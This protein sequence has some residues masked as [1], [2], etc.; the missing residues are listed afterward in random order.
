[1][2]AS[3]KW[4][5]IPETADKVGVTIWRLRPEQAGDTGARLMVQRVPKVPERVASDA[6]LSRGDQVFLSVESP[7]AG[8]LYIIDREMYADGTVSDPYL[9][10]P[11]RTTRGGDNRVEAGKL[12]GI[13]DERDNPNVFTLEPQPPR[14]DQVGEHLSIV[15]TNKPLETFEPAGTAARF[16]PA[17]ALLQLR[18]AQIAAWEARWGGRNEQFDLD[19]GAGQTMTLAEQDAA[20]PGVG[21]RLLIQAAPAPQTVYLVESKSADGL[22][23]SVQLRYR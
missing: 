13:P 7:R 10:F 11:T 20:K 9:I 14:N 2:Q 17:D 16:T 8:Y 15:I 12:I 18:P 19:G 21:A 3:I 6:V 22:L 5:D 23:V 1:V 4:E